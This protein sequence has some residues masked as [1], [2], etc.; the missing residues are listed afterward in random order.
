MIIVIGKNSKLF[1]KT[2]NGGRDIKFC[3]Y[4]FEKYQGGNVG[5]EKLKKRN[6]DYLVTG[7]GEIIEFK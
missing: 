3:L 1:D 2:L 6:P 5:P 4:R 7:L